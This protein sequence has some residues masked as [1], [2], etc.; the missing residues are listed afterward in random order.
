MGHACFGFP[1]AVDQDSSVTILC[2][3]PTVVLGGKGRVPGL[4]IGC[5]CAATVHTSVTVAACSIAI[6]QQR[7]WVIGHHPFKT[8]SPKL[9][10]CFF[11]SATTGSVCCGR[12]QQ[13]W[14]PKFHLPPQPQP[15]YAA[16]KAHTVVGPYQVP[17]Y[18]QQFLPNSASMAHQTRRT[19]P[20]WHTQPAIGRG[21]WPHLQPPLR[22]WS[23]CGRQARSSGPV[24]HVEHVEQSR[25]KYF[26]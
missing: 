19:S 22:E 17:I 21:T 26:Q 14:C 24:E 15:P 7:K 8:D 25:V 2:R 16:P 12:C 13:K 11:H 5:R 20:P 9:D 3:P 18:V 4:G 10:T 23:G 6:F 1:P